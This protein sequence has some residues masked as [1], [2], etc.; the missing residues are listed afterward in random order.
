MNNNVNYFKD[1]KEQLIKAIDTAMLQIEIMKDVLPSGALNRL[2]EQIGIIKSLYPPNFKQFILSQCIEDGK[3]NATEFILDF[4]M[5]DYFKI[6]VERETHKK[7]EPNT[8]IKK[9]WYQL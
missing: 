3:I 9:K 4:G 6:T 7:E 5:S 1:Q 8:N 2:Y